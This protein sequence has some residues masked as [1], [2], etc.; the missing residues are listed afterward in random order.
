MLDNFRY[1]KRITRIYVGFVDK[2]RPLTLSL[3]A[4]SNN[5]ANIG[6]VIARVSEAGH[7]N[8]TE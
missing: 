1:T 2:G 5:G 6:R 3:T 8:C 7:D 4:A